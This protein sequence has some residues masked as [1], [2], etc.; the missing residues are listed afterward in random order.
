MKRKG[1]G[2]QKESMI[3]CGQFITKI[4]KWKNLLFEEMLNSL[5]ALIYYRALDTTTLR[6][7]FDFEGKLIPKV[8]EPDVPRVAI[9]RPPRASMQ[10][11]Y[12]RMGS[13]EICQGAIERMEHITYLVMISSSTTSI[14]SSIT[15][16]SSQEMM[17]M[18]MRNTLNRFKMRGF[19]ILL[20]ASTRQ[21]LNMISSLLAVRVLPFT[22]DKFVE[23]SIIIIYVRDLGSGPPPKLWEQAGTSSGQAPFKPSSPGSTSDVVEAFGTVG[24][25]N[26][27][28]ST[29]L[30]QL[31]RA[32]I[33]AE[34][35]LC[36]KL[37]KLEESKKVHDYFLRSGFRVD[38]GLVHKGM[39]F[40]FAFEATLKLT[41]NHKQDISH[42][43]IFRSHHLPTI[44]SQNMFTIIVADGL[45]SKMG[46]VDINTLTMEQYLALTRGNQVPGL[47]R[48]EIGNN[49]NFEIKSQFMRKLRENTFSS[50]KNDDAHEHME[51]VLDIGPIPEMT[52]T[53]ALESIQSM[54]DH[55][56]KWHDRSSIRGTSSGSSDGIAAI[57]RTHL[58]KDYSLNKEVKEIE[59]VKYG[60]GRS[61]LNNGRSR[62]RY[63]MGQLGYYTRMD[64]CPHFGKKKQSLEEK[65]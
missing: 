26:D 34:D 20:E 4:A 16:N 3:C 9:P 19:G 55:S 63:R 14:I 35:R 23:A 53:Q 38:V 36:G 22:L 39:V 18:M 56:Q 62:A 58:D 25:T 15:S 50:C 49:V 61:F 24:Y 42:L 43:F 10:D 48:P 65:N 44:Q 40:G 27:G 46:D 57:T 29:L 2:S 8:L 28:K 17:M 45:S 54:T 32:N 33:L 5:S 64:N 21:T 51:R 31:T 47:V 37:K 59:E 11:F 41:D 12:E 1:A 6:E 7:L 13:M 52:P 60:I 30:D